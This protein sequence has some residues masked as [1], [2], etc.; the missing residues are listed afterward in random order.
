MKKNVFK[1]TDEEKK[2]FVEMSGSIILWISEGR[3]ITY[4]SDKLNLKPSQ[5]EHNIEEILYTVRNQVGIRR[6]MK[7]LFTKWNRA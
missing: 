6:F 1:M 3:S 5:V 7:A 2:R 4:M